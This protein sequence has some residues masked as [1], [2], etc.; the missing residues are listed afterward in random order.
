MADAI[1][2]QVCYALPD[3]QI[4][5]D[6]F[7]AAGT[8][9]QQAIERSGILQEFPGIDLTKNPVGIF[10]KI[11]QLDAILVENDRAEIYRP[12]IVDPK[13]ARRRRAVKK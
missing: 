8:T 7:V 12:L 13:E 11:R 1:P 4:V 6:L 5:R 10:G 3:R 2:V 9:L